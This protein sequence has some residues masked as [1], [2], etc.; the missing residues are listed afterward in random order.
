MDYSII[1][2][3]S[4]E[5]LVQL[6]DN[7]IDTNSGYNYISGCNLRVECSNGRS[8]WM[9]ISDYHPYLWCQVCGHCRGCRWDC[10]TADRICGSTSIYSWECVR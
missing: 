5:E 10:A 1:N 8:G 9:Q 7:I 2:E 3:I 6:Y 4:N